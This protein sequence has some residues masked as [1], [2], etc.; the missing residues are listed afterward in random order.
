MH[1][2]YYLIAVLRTAILLLSLILSNSLFAE[3]IIMSS[4]PV[5]LSCQ[6]SSDT[7]IL[8]FSNTET[9]AITINIKTKNGNQMVSKSNGRSKSQMSF[10]LDNFPMHINLS[11]QN[12]IQSFV[13]DKNCKVTD[14]K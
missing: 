3:N 8:V 6:K 1:Y 9:P 4:I 12:E 13:V 10:S 5:N 2:F 14:L 7:I 11:N